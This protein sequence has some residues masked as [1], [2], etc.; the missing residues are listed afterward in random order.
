[1]TESPLLD[2]RRI[3]TGATVAQTELEKI[4]TA[5]DPWAI[6]QTTPGVL[7]DR[8]NVGGNESGQQSQYVGPGAMGT[9]AVWS[10]DGVVITDM[11]AL[12]SSPAYYDFDAFEEMQVTTGGSDTTIATGG[13][14]LNMVTKRGT[15]EWRGSGRYYDTDQKWQ[16]SSNTGS[17]DFAPGQPAFKQGNRIVNVRDCGAEVGGPIIKDRLW[18]WGSY[19]RQKVS[20][21]TIADVSDKTDL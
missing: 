8:I 1:T 13:V 15:N 20:L 21:L 3:S 19:G 9:Q 18:I 11:A 7:T 10:V 17:V 4:P 6:L 12:G 2:E 5:R 14:V 16:S